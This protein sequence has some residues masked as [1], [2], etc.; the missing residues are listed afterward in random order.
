MTLY[1]EKDPAYG[2]VNMK[3]DFIKQAYIKVCGS[4]GSFSEM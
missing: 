4:G 1:S 3:H 2:S